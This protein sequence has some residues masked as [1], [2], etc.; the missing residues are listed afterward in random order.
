TQRQSFKT[1]HG[2]TTPIGEP[3]ITCDNRT[4][5]L[6]R[7]VCKHLFFG[8]RTWTNNELVGSQNKMCCQ[9]CT[10]KF[11]CLSKYF[12]Y[13]TSL[14]IENA[15]SVILQCFPGF[16]TGDQTHRFVHREFSSE[17]S[18]TEETGNMII[19]TILLDTV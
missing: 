6:T 9:P 14:R 7:R 12:L 3:V 11:G 2:V 16:D 8:P 1:D 17:I 15:C 13:P 19:A 10:S 4:H 18:G 5:L